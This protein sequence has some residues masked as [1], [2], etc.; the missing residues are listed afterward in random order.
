MQDSFESN[1][2]P[3]TSNGEYELLRSLYSD[4][5]KN[6][7]AYNSIAAN[8]DELIL[9]VSV[10]QGDL[11]S[12]LNV[13][14]NLEIFLNEAEAKAAALKKTTITCIKGKLVKKV[15]GVKPV[16]PKGYKKK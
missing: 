8:L 3:H 5:S 13:I 15:T 4:Y 12:Q 2:L 16:C 1:L 7:Q 9:Y 11:T 14:K 6:E 10:L